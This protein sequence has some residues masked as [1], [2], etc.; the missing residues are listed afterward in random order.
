M[1]ANAVREWSVEDLTRWLCSIGLSDVAVAVSAQE[2]DGEVFLSLSEG[3]LQ[4][5]LGVAPASAARL[6]GLITR[7]APRGKGKVKGSSSSKSEVDR[8]AWKS[9]RSPSQKNLPACSEPVET[10]ESPVTFSRSRA[11]SRSE[12]DKQKAAS[13]PPSGSPV[14]V[15]VLPHVDNSAPS[16]A[17]SANA[18]PTS[19]QSSAIPGI[20]KRGVNNRSRSSVRTSNTKVSPKKSRYSTLGRLFSRNK[21]EAMEQMAA[22]MNNEENKISSLQEMFR[23]SDEITKRAIEYRQRLLVSL[24]TDPTK[25]LV[26]D[27]ESIYKELSVLLEVLSE[28][29]ER[30]T[31]TDIHLPDQGQSLADRRDALVKGSAVM[32]EHVLRNIA[33]CKTAAAKTTAAPAYVRRVHN[34]IDRIKVFL[35]TSVLP[36]RQSPG[37]DDGRSSKIRSEDLTAGHMDGSSSS[38]NM[39]RRMQFRESVSHSN[40]LNDAAPPPRSFPD[41]RRYKEKR[42]SSFMMLSG[43]SVI[44]AADPPASSSLGSILGVSPHQFCFSV[45]IISSTSTMQYEHVLLEFD[46]VEEVLRRRR[47]SRK[48]RAFKDIGFSLIERMYREENS[49][50]PTLSIVTYSCPCFTF[51]AYPESTVA[52]IEQ[53]LHIVLSRPSTDQLLLKTEKFRP[54]LCLKKALVSTKKGKKPSQLLYLWEGGVL[55]FN[56]PDTHSEVL[57][58][59]DLWSGIASKREEKVLQLD[60]RLAKLQLTFGSESER[61]SFAHVCERALKMGE[62]EM[63]E[64]H[65]RLVR[66]STEL[67]TRFCEINAQHMDLLRDLW[68]AMKATGEVAVRS[69]AWKTGLGFQTDTPVESD[70]GML[71]LICISYITKHYPELFAR[72]VGDRGTAVEYPFATVGHQL[73][74]MLVK[75]LEIPNKYTNT[76][77]PVPEAFPFFSYHPYVFEELYCIALQLFERVWNE[78]KATTSMMS[79]VI[80]TTTERF[81]EMCERPPIN[82]NG[83]DVPSIFD[84]LG[85]ILDPT[86]TLP[87]KSHPVDESLFFQ[88]KMAGEE[89]ATKEETFIEKGASYSTEAERENALRLAVLRELHA[90]E[91]DYVRDLRVLISVFLKPLQRSV[92]MISEADMRHVFCGIEDLLPINDDLQRDL[93][94]LLRRPPED[95]VVTTVFDRMVERFKVYNAYCSAHAVSIATLN[96]LRATNSQFS[97]FIEERRKEPRAKQGLESF[98]IKPVQRIC[99]YP[100][101]LKEALK[102]TDARHADMARLQGTIDKFEELVA[103]INEHKRA[104]ESSLKVAEIEASIAMPEG[105]ESLCAPG[106]VF[107]ASAGMKSAVVGSSTQKKPTLFLFSDLLL[108]V[109]E[110]AASANKEKGRPYQLKFS[111]PAASMVVPDMLEQPGGPK[112]ECTFIFKHKGEKVQVVTSSP[113]QK[114]EWLALLFDIVKA[115]E[116]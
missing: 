112:G 91:A 6:M 25:A 103:E 90:T 88:R 13:S 61:D 5:Q 53:L 58:A 60:A 28:Y 27:I 94:A 101:L 23:T 2:V 85:V 62:P 54:R 84:L 11:N 34:D 32:V 35:D 105:S 68:A 115:K 50:F 86:L 24:T 87:E 114:I 49:A 77:Y 12:A 42:H 19:A 109:R 78:M 36:P 8:N 75:N 116:K 18:S 51:H 80:A 40:L 10:K 92:G 46:V 39:S 72:H 20:T 106:R 82:D 67:D 104:S 45:F 74:K 52:R 15:P 99:R 70:V 111:F 43:G 22:E 55:L 107:K 59:F 110:V 9:I 83:V 47:T 97:E 31:A 108:I 14:A 48:E 79:R 3:E 89:K 30:S 73:I 71:H 33:C 38:P 65:S 113:G 66:L 21:K 26:N 41:M 1:D 93:E 29:S 81:V 57:N 44:A 102:H 100:L 69:P 95:Q 96:R 16:S 7:S 17:S 56:G 37:S 63:Q 4:T 76:N 64:T 98:L